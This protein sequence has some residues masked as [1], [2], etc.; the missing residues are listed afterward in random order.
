M[1][2]ITNANGNMHASRQV[3][4]EKVGYYVGTT[5]CGHVHINAPANN[6]ISIYKRT[7]KFVG[8]PQP[9]RSGIEQETKKIPHVVSGGANSLAYD[10]TSQLDRP[11]L[12]VAQQF[13]DPPGPSR[14]KKTSWLFFATVLGAIG[15]IFGGSNRQQLDDV[16]CAVKNTRGRQT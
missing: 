13:Q 1:A 12:D 7:K 9:P 5:Y 15:T 16:Q 8:A 2:D 6:S 4:F 10:A 14:E 11:Y 3:T